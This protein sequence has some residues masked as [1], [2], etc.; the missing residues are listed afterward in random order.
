MGLSWTVSGI[1]APKEV[2]AGLEWWGERSSE[3]GRIDELEKR[4]EKRR[5]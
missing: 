3:S 5:D 2:S 1:S 4:L